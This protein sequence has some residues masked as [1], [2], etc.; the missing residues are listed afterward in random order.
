[1]QRFQI[2]RDHEF[3]FGIVDLVGDLAFGIKRVVIDDHG[4]AFQNG[5]VRGDEIRAIREK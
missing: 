1:M 2:E 4:A 3:R 5:E